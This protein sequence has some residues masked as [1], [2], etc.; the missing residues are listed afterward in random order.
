MANTN[1][2]TIAL[3]FEDEEQKEEVKE[4][5]TSLAKQ[6]YRSPSAYIRNLILEHVYKPDKNL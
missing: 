6:E 2:W 3:T 1:T 4:K 5:I